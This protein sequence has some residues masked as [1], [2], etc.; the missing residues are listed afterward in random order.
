[1]GES[2]AVDI[3]IRRL[4][5]SESQRWRELRLRALAD[6]PE[7]FGSA[8]EVEVER[9]ASVW[10]ERTEAFAAGQDRVMFVAEDPDG[11]LLGCA[12]VVIEPEAGPFV[13]SMWLDPARR[14]EGLGWRL[15]EAVA[16]WAEA[17]GFGRLRLMVV[18]GN[19]AARD[20]YLR[21]GFTTTGVTER[22]QRGALEEEMSLELQRAP[23]GPT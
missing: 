23:G 19:R 9:P 16:G 15:L 11:R 17:Q 8:Y 6:A 3:V 13:I 22:N 14:G 20:L 12:G 2:S 18:R 1:M 7:A 5:A 4:R 21:F 10:Q